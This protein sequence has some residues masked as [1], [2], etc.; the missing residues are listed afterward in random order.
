MPRPRRT[1]KKYANRRL[2]DTETSQSI[3]LQDVRDLIGSG[4]NVTVVEAKSGNEVTRQVLLQIVADQELLGR[5]VLSNEF[6][7]AMIRVNSNPMRDLSRSY[8]EKVMI[9]IES[10]QERVES[11]WSQM[12]ASSGLDNHGA[13][14]LEPFRQFQRRMFSMWSE[15]LFPPLRADEPS[16]EADPEDD[17]PER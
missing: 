15:A 2:Y 5:P 14:P 3:T 17:P 4:E 1:I 8:L 12:L 13:N 9:H 16:T 7:E 11:A 6:L 10:Q